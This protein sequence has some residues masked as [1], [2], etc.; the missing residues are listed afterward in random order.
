MSKITVFDRFKALNLETNKQDMAEVGMKVSTLYQQVFGEKPEKE[1]RQFLGLNDKFNVYP[2]DFS[3]I[4]DNTISDYLKSERRRF[5]LDKP[6]R[7]EEA[8]KRY[9][10]SLRN[11]DAR[12]VRKEKAIA[13][14]ERKKRKRIATPGYVKVTAA[15]ATNTKVT[16][17]VVDR[18]K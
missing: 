17:K 4:I 16:A 8:R 12:I 18:N 3:I 2:A 10:E 13:F 15:K 11:R 5:L 9:E 6:K 1:E 14:K 7:V